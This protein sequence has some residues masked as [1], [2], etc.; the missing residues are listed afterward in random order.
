[1][2]EKGVC[3]KCGAIQEFLR[4]LYADWRGDNVLQIT[5]TPILKGVRLDD[6]SEE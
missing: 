1:M 3:K 4:A 5:S 2:R 6:E